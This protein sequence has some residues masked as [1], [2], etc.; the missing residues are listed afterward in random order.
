MTILSFS[1]CDIGNRTSS[2]KEEQI[3]VEPTQNQLP[4][5]E[6]K[7]NEGKQD[8]EPVDEIREQVDKM[9]LD[10]KIG[11]M[12]IVGIDGYSLND[13]SVALIEKYKVGGFIVMGKNVQSS[14][15]LL[16]L[17]NSIKEKNIKNEIPL[18]FSI[19]EEGGRVTRMPKE[20]TRLPSN[21]AIG[22]INNS[23]FSRDIGSAIADEISSFGFNMDF[24]PV[25]DVNSNP[26]N[27]VIGDRSYGSNAEIVSNLGVQTMLGLQ[28]GN[29]IPVVKHFP[30]HGD[31]S[32]DSHKGLPSVN[33]DLKRLESLELVP[34]EQAIKNNV[35][36]I[37]IAHILLPKID[38]ENPSSMSKTIITDILRVKLNFNG[39]VITDD[40]TM[41]AIVKNYNIGE[42]AV[43]SVSAGT[44]IVLVCHG[45]ENEVAVISAIKSAISNG[46]ISE[47]RIDESVY[48][49]L[50]LKQS[51][52]LKDEIKSSIDVNKI[53]ARMKSVL[54]TY[55]K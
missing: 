32:V 55:M 49:I 6:I 39:V 48:R 25:L 40:M 41:G 17:L 5:N 24:A 28:S 4:N 33:N 16:N 13:N 34:F 51:Y 37:M 43:K 29:V 27:P 9:S 22:K 12:M 54:N 14:Q 7:D 36:V 31:T 3:K 42:A 21:K 30:G 26:K 44:D 10:E 23:S 1:G 20:F 11:Q 8:G 47:Q 19:D 18:F 15:Q 35:D 45:Y 52:E 2:D 38:K 53:N 50:K 46:H